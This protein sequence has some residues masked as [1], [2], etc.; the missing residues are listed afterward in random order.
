MSVPLA[1]FLYSF[2]GDVG[3][4]LIDAQDL[5]KLANWTIGAATGITALAGGAQAGSPVL[6]YSL[7]TVT[8]V[9]SGNDSV[10]L[11][12][13]LPGGYVC[14]ENAGAQTMRIYAGAAGNVTNGGALDQ[15]RA[16]GTTALT[17]NGTA[18]TLASGSS[19]EFACTTAGI[20]K[21]LY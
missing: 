17:A 21:R 2:Y 1:S 9:A 12:P 8:T 13:A 4:Q 3:L 18:V 15:I 19:T 5:T 11:P 16:S 14:V 6:P 10:Q 7:V 20:W